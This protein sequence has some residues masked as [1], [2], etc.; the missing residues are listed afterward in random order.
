MCKKHRQF[1][2]VHYADAIHDSYVTDLEMFL[3]SRAFFMGMFFRVVSEE[4]ISFVIF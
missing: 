4:T 1:D 3:N 2:D